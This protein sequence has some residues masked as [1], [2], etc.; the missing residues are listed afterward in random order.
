MINGLALCAE[1]GGIELGLELVFGEQ[2]R[3]IEMSERGE[4]LPATSS[5][6]ESS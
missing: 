3:T 5:R 1:Y 6:R 2:Y 4:P